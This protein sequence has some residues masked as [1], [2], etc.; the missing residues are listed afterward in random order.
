MTL[1]RFIAFSWRAKNGLKVSLYPIDLL[2]FGLMSW[3]ATVGLV[4]WWAFLIYLVSSIN[5][6]RKR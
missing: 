1:T 2:C 4:P 3:G 6:E 5:I